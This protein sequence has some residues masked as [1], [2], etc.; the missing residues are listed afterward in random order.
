MR[1]IVVRPAPPAL[2][3]AI[4]AVIT[5]ATGSASGHSYLVS[6]DPP[7]G[8]A[9]STAPRQ[10]ILT[11]SLPVVP[12]LA[13]VS[14]VDDRGLN[15]A[16]TAVAA[17]PGAPSALVV[18][19][20]PLPSGGYRLAWRAVAASDLHV[21]SGSLVFGIGMPAPAPAAQPAASANPL[22]VL[23]RW[24][25]T[26]GLAVLGGALTLIVIIQRRSPLGDDWL[27]AATAPARLRR[28]L[29]GLAAL[30]AG[31]GL[32]SG[33]ALFALQASVAGAAQ[34]PAAETAG[35]V[36][37]QRALTTDFGIASLASEALLL[38]I[39]VLAI[40]SRRAPALSSDGAPDRGSFRLSRSEVAGILTLAVLALVQA[41]AGHVA[42]GPDSERPV[43][44]AALAAHLFAVW[45]W[46][47]GLLVLSLAVLPLLRR[48]AAERLLA[49]NVL[50]RFWLIAVPALGVLAVTGLYL[51]GQFVA[52][53]DALILSPYGQALT[54]KGG[55]VAAAVL[56]GLRNSAS[57]HP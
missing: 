41:L 38:A 56:L 17:I 18:D 26:T 25:Q 50:R 30:G 23:L 9:L 42:T 22:E 32:A 20:P 15:V 47:G 10:V 35:T 4:I 21:T 29:H 54:V 7:D 13:D 52:T 28:R 8:S 36:P 31:G 46:F 16:G 44:T 48:G 3:L 2:V 57:L 51:S 11:F 55:L 49:R 34:G 33:G 5:L 14:V 12:S 53:V 45:A 43:R 27:A 37:W 6:T 19:L 24:L 39:L 40:R 1:Q